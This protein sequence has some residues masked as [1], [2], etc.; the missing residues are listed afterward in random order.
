MAQRKNPMVFTM[1]TNP[2]ERA[3]LHA[4]AQARGISAAELIR[5][6]LRSQGALPAK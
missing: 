3:Q 2:T 1:K 6:A 4:A 5:Q